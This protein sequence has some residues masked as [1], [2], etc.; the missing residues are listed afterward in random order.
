MLHWERSVYLDTDGTYH[1]EATNKVVEGVKVIRGPFKT[2]REL[3]KD[4][5]E[6]LR[7]GVNSEEV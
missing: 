4:Y 7:S 1:W 5:A 6:F 3:D 2:R